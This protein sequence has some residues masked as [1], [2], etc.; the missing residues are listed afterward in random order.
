M[1]LG[2]Q[3]TAGL[4]AAGLSNWSCC[5]TLTRDNTECSAMYSINEQLEVSNNFAKN[6]VVM[7]RRH[8]LI[9]G[10]IWYRLIG[11]RTSRFEPF[12]RWKLELVVHGTANGMSSRPW[13]RRFGFCMTRQ[14][15]RHENTA[16]R[17]R[18]SA[19]TRVDWTLK[20]FVIET[21]A[22]CDG[23]HLCRLVSSLER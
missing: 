10:D 23:E 19:T 2:D 3:T 12:R 15:D 8:N 11:Q 4:A 16:N 21:Y 22:N 13:L 6:V 5:R 20:R 9:N 1:D 7:N 17:K 14:T 18:Q